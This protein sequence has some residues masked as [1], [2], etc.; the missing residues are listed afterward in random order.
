MLGIRCCA[1]FRGFRYGDLVTY[2]RMFKAGETSTS[3]AKKKSGK[4]KTFPAAAAPSASTT[5]AAAIAR[6]TA[7]S[8][9]KTATAAAA[10]ATAVAATN[11]A[12]DADVMDDAGVMDDSDSD[13]AGSMIRHPAAAV[14]PKHLASI[15]P[16]LAKLPAAEVAG[17]KQLACSARA[18][19]LEEITVYYKVLVAHGP[20]YQAIFDLL[21]PFSSKT[22]GQVQKYHKNVCRTYGDLV[23]FVKT[24]KVG[25]FT[26]TAVAHPAAGKPKK[27]RQS[28]STTPVKRRR[29]TPVSSPKGA[30]NDPSFQDA[31]SAAAT[32]VESSDG[33]RDRQSSMGPDD[34][35]MMP[36]G[37]EV[38]NAGL[39]N[40]RILVWWPSARAAYEA[41]VD[42]Y[43]HTDGSHH[44]RYD[45][46]EALWHNLREFRWNFADA[47]ARPIGQPAKKRRT[48]SGSSGGAVGH[49]S[50]A[51]VRAKDKATPPSKL[52]A[53]K[54]QKRAT[55]PT[56]TRTELDLATTEDWSDA[57]SGP[58][59]LPE[60][61]TVW[62]AIKK[63]DDELLDRVLTAG[64]DVNEP[65]EDGKI[66]ILYAARYGLDDIVD[67][68]IEGGCDIN[69]T[70]QGGRT[71]LLWAA[72]N[73]DD[74]IV[75]SL[76]A[77]Q[78][79]VNR[80]D[81]GDGWTPCWWAALKGHDD[82]VSLLVEANADVDREDKSGKTPLTYALKH[83][84]KR[85]VD[86]LIVGSADVN[87]PDKT[88]K[89]PIWLAS[90]SMIERLINA[91]ADVD[92]VDTDGRTMLNWA[93]ES[94]REGTV[95]FLLGAN[96]TVNQAVDSTGRSA[97]GWAALNGNG[98]VVDALLDANANVEHSGDPET[99]LEIVFRLQHWPAFD[100]LLQAGASL[101]KVLAHVDGPAVIHVIDDI[102]RSPLLR[103]VQ[104][105]SC[106]AAASLIAAAADVNTADKFGK[107]PALWCAKNGHND[108]MS[109]L[110]S[111]NADVMQADLDGETPLWWAARGGHTN[112]VKQLIKANSNLDR[113]DSN[114]RERKTP[115]LCAA[116]N[117]HR[118]TVS[119]LLGAG[120]EVAAMDKDGRNTLLWAAEYGWSDVVV[121]LV[122]R[123]A[124]VNVVD[125]DGEVALW[126]AA[127][128]GHLE[129]VES[130]IQAGANVNRACPVRGAKIMNAETSAPTPLWCAVQQNHS[131]CVSTLVAAGADTDFVNDAG[132]TPLWW[133]LKHGY[134]KMAET[135]LGLSANVDKLAGTGKSAVWLAMRRNDAGLLEKVLTAGGSP[136]DMDE[137]EAGE[138]PLVHAARLGHHGFVGCLLAASGDPDV[139][140]KD[141]ATP[142]MLAVEH[143]DAAL[144]EVLLG[145]N[146]DPN[147]AG[148]DGRTALTVCC[149]TNGNPKIVELLVQAQASV[150]QTNLRGDTPLHVYAKRGRDRAPGL[151]V[152]TLLAANSDLNQTN[153][154]GQSVLDLASRPSVVEALA[155]WSRGDAP[156]SK[157]AHH[158][159]SPQL[160]HCVWSTLL[161]HRRW[162][163]GAGAA[164]ATTPELWLLIFSFL[165]DNQFRQTTVSLA[166]RWADS[167]SLRTTPTV[168]DVDDDWVEM[169]QRTARRFANR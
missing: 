8:R 27:G 17:L 38:D 45:D 52:P 126:W 22:Y 102:G 110:L 143:D 62:A 78:A 90:A 47:D 141:G 162:R 34:F 74:D 88:G 150:T 1:H 144:V 161:S 41:M 116:M 67:R 4:K 158:T 26:T 5:T 6:A 132:D 73:G 23:K 70:D 148:R 14:R 154:Y 107:T 19:S 3:V 168:F 36:A 135:L 20:D 119:A 87:R 21:Q 92:Q 124:D 157:S 76:I 160:R 42:T 81:D 114:G 86:A 127:K 56:K 137:S 49:P 89:A 15:T 155:A 130:L 159:L 105:G 29:S 147:I 46:G 33:E 69:R 59:G 61:V 163:S 83:N 16:S 82:V 112:I 75:A 91:N 55:R 64:G 128:H 40:Q 96:C 72:K 133:A 136:S 63:D 120:A 53:K 99:P 66:P 71:P 104:R 152:N 139:P 57:A 97:L 149:A 100:S 80:P 77:A 153:N 142:L 68:L 165:T 113:I 25:A 11:A 35:G 98:A 145:S 95:K 18:W 51:G 39:V 9:V 28:G 129:M 169:L 101:D 146:A 111:S 138:P 117:G 2:V 32:G 151:V 13:Q 44:L 167:M 31:F 7:A 50:A 12:F 79:D 93:C 125:K 54:L 164:A 65:D 30:G 58:K 122:A 115:L 156:W 103:S 118:A 106:Q 140:G 10:A 94:D 108:V 123:N 131:G 24:F 48:S 84:L 166:M 85:M 43:D 60:V 134:T 121:Q 109:L 37:T